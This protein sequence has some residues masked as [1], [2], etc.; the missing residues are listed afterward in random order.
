M[1]TSVCLSD[2]I[3]IFPDLLF[4]VVSLTTAMPESLSQLDMEVFSF[5]FNP[6][7]D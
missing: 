3:Q 4:D 7:Y 5:S 6:N 1:I 2:D